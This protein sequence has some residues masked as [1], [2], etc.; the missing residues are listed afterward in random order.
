MQAAILR[1]KFPSYWL[2]FLR[3]PYSFIYAVGPYFGV[4]RDLVKCA[5]NQTLCH[6]DFDFSIPCKVHPLPLS[7]VSSSHAVRST[8]VRLQST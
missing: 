7:R 3:A 5:I 4:P 6:S 2:P 8:H 1:Q